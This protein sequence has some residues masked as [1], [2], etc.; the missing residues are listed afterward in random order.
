MATL[1]E[2]TERIRRAAAIGEPLGRTLKLDL[3]G[4]GVIRLNGRAVGND[5]GPADLVVSVSRADLE[6]LGKGELDPGRAMMTGR[7]KLSD[8]G[9]ALS[10]KNEIQ[11]LFE[12]AVQR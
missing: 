11:A 10:L 8:M 3:R 7:M 6:R 1:D 12:R 9:L 2:L 5:D 4:E